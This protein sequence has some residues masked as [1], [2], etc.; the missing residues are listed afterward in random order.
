[1]IVAILGI[2]GALV[3]Y[4]AGAKPGSR[5]NVQKLAKALKKCEKDKSKRKRRACEKTAQAKYKSKAPGGNTDT[6]A[7]APTATGTGAATG[8]GT[9]TAPTGTTTGIGATTG[10]TA[11]T[12]GART[13][14]SAEAVRD[15]SLVP[16]QPNAALYIRVVTHGGQNEEDALVRIVGSKIGG[17]VFVEGEAREFNP[18]PC[19]PGVY[20]V[21]ALAAPKVPCWLQRQ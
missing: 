21:A 15:P 13:P 19:I 20:E 1:M 10:T 9:A 4:P 14:S 16:G 2:A 12:T 6:G 7:G 18:W 11:T 8:T 3:A 5:H 17:T